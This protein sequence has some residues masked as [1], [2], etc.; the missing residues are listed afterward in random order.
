[1]E[2]D[3]LCKNQA[4]HT[5]NGNLSVGFAILNRTQHLLRAGHEQFSDILHKWHAV[6]VFMNGQICFRNVQQVP[7]PFIVYLEVSHLYVELKVLIIL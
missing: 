4:K 2:F 1:M 6:L 3:R 7:D 5:R